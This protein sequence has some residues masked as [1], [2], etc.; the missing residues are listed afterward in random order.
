MGDLRDLR[1][2]GDLG[3]LEDLGDLRDLGDLGD[4]GVDVRLWICLSVPSNE[5]GTAW[6]GDFWSKSIWLILQN[7]EPFF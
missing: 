3:D 2:L 7:Y 5:T 4:L 1:D 6:I